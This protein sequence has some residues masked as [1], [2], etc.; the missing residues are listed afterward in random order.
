LGTRACPLYGARKGRKDGPTISAV[1]AGKQ[2][3]QVRYKEIEQ[4]LVAILSPQP[5]ALVLEPRTGALHQLAA[6]SILRKVVGRIT[7]QVI[8]GW[9]MQRAQSP[10]L[11]L[12]RF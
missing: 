8:E 9:A 5:L 2:A 1:G 12:S 11:I 10:A 3:V 6:L 4:L 7:P